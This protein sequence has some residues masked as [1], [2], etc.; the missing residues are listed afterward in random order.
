MQNEI[1]INILLQKWPKNTVAVYSWLED[2]GISES[3]A[4]YYR[5][6]GWLDSFGVGAFI[7][8]G[9]TNQIVLVLSSLQNYGSGAR[10]IVAHGTYKSNP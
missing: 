4:D 9:D 10:E 3:L 2:N 6:S 1:K 5:K 7:R 8:R